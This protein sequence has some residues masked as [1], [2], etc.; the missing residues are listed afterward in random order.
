[1]AERKREAKPAQADALDSAILRA[2]ASASTQEGSPLVQALADVHERA[3][4]L[5]IVMNSTSAFRVVAS[6][7]P[8]LA[9][10][11]SAISES[12]RTKRWR[13]ARRVATDR[14]AK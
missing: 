2:G 11:I 7:W 5:G 13:L 9:E 1:M 8:E 3:C 12:G 4:R 6:H 14:G 10:Q